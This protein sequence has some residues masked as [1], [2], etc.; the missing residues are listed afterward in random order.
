MA[1]TPYTAIIPMAI[2]ATMGIM[3][4]STMRKNIGLAQWTFTQKRHLPESLLLEQQHSW[5]CTLQPRKMPWER[6]RE[7]GHLMMAILHP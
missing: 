6:G 3:S 7:E 5:E 1:M 4:T 2:M